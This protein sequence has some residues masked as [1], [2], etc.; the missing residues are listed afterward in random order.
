[1]YKESK[2]KSKIK[3]EIFEWCKTIVI[4]LVIAIGISL[5][6]QPTIVNGQSMYPTLENND[7]LLVNKLTYKSGV[8]NRGDIIIFHTDLVDQTTNKNKDLV[9][10]V[11][12]LPNEHLIIKD[13]KFYI[14]DELLDEDYINGVY[15]EGDIDIIVP[16][17]HVF[18]M[19]DNR[20][21][22]DD[23]RK[24]Y[25]GSVALEDIVGKAFIRVY[26]FT[27]LKKFD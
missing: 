20:P 19:G 18:A 12:A 8:P 7:L 1:M 15:T 6:A 21:N 5:A 11:I 27:E 26:P 9:K 13:G 25:V 16:S 3:Q 17:N 23:S 4:S 10:R 24:S 2:M 22:S 14:N